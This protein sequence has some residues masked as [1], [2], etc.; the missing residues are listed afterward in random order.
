MFP[1]GLIILHTQVSSS[2]KCPLYSCFSPALPSALSPSHSSWTPNSSSCLSH[3]K[4][5]FM[6][7][8][9]AYSSTSN[10]NPPFS[11]KAFPEDFLASCPCTYWY[12]SFPKCFGIS[13]ISQ[14]MYYFHHLL[15]LYL[16][17]TADGKYSHEIKRLLLF[18]RKV[19]TNLDSALKSRDIILLTKVCKVIVFP[20]VRYGCES[21]TI[22][23]AEHRRIDALNCGVGEDSWESLGLQGDQTRPS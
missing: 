4:L 12:F 1:E 6:D 8:D 22:K 5:F 10:P 18:G 3:G 7:S 23:K 21:W 14:F 17:I 2:S 16:N 11:H 9:Q 13:C 19:M 15:L 20:V